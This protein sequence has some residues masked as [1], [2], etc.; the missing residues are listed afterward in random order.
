MI[1]KILITGGCGFVG[2]NLG[3]FL[4]KKGFK[5]TSLDNLYRLGS[6]LNYKR[7]KKE[8][9]ENLKLD[10]KNFDKINRIENKFDLIIDCCA[11]PSV[12]NSRKSIN[13]A[14]RVMETN[15]TG[16]FNVVSKCLKDNSI[17]IFLSSSRVYSITE[18]N[19]YKKEINKKKYTKDFGIDLKTSYP[20]SLYGFTKLASEE[21]IKEFSYSNKLKYIINR[22]GVISGPWQ[23]G[24]IDQGFISLWCW[25]HLMKQNLKYIGFGGTGKQVRDVLHIDDL[26]ELIFLQIKN[27]KKV[28][29]L[30]LSFG[31]GKV[32]SINLKKLTQKI[33]KFSKNSINISKI[34]KTSIYDIPYFVASNKIVNDIYKWKPKKTINDI[35]TD[36]YNW[37]KDNLKILKKI[38]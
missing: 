35:I 8:K 27:I 20:R 33:K 16:T 32:N 34:K 17:L 5:I 9:I 12:E 22:I 7:L 6:K 31:G 13:E 3:I 24:K 4:K 36:V 1:K 28:N 14:K 11:E 23:F 37:Q 2:S 10:I 29:N 25:S 19:K 15:L 38:F 21:L 26:C 30:S 18:L